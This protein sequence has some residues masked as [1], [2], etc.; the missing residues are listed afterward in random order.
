M[1]API[2]LCSKKQNG[3][4]LSSCEAEYITVIEATCQWLETL[5]EELKLEHKKQFSCLLIINILL[6]YLRIQ[7]FM[8]GLNILKQN[9]IF[10]E[11]K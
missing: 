3:V 8:T 6:V 1:N 9:S 10:L 5:L 7:F 11:I 2:S 4:A